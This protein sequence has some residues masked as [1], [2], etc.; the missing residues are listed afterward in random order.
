VTGSLKQGKIGDL[1]NPQLNPRESMMDE[2]H[3]FSRLDN[4]DTISVVP[5]LSETPDREFDQTLFTNNKLALN[6]TQS[7]LAASEL[8]RYIDVTD[9]D[10]YHT[11]KSLL[12]MTFG[13]QS[14]IILFEDFKAFLYEKECFG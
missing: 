2:S 12:Q 6:L 1:I 8:C 4:D 13:K 7:S 10:A 9:R 11:V 3:I 5:P 14:D